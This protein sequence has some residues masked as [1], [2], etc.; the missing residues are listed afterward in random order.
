MRIS[1]AWAQQLGVNAMQAQQAKMSKTQMQLSSGLKQLS[2]SDDPSA[3]ARVLDLE[4]SIE[5]T[6][7]YQAN[8]FATR[9]RLNIEE[10]ALESSENVIIRVKEL[11]VQALNGTLNASDRLAIKQEVDQ[12]IQELAGLA[13]TKNANGEFIFSGDLSNEPTYVMDP[14]TGKYVYQG[15]VHQRALPIGPERQVADGDLGSNVFENIASVSRYKNEDGKRSIFNTLQALS[16]SLA[17]DFKPQQAT[18]TGDRFL[19]YGLAGGSS[20][21]LVSDGGTASIALT[22]EF[23]NLDALVTEINS[24]IETQGMKNSMQARTNGNK[25]EFVSL[26]TGINSTIKIQNANVFFLDNAGFKEGQSNAADNVF[27][28]EDDLRLNKPEIRR[29]STEE[30]YNANLGN[31]LTDLDSALDS[32]LQAR[33]SV[34]A[35]LRALDDQE[36]QNDKFIIDTRSTLSATQ[37]L[38][39]AEAISRFNLQQMSLQAAQQAFSQVQRLSLF[40]YL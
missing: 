28:N 14:D 32:L 30:V 37:D 23:T 12:L 3:A 4:K 1:T 17:G 6:S 20:F 7:Q 35:R 38:D 25:V 40:N 36:S 16:D 33:T 18:I 2:P 21:D 29:F 8:I 39:Y 26:T 22:A 5:K 9:G 24:Q 11:T 15:G 10:S 34:G 31:V 27:L 19:R 13:N